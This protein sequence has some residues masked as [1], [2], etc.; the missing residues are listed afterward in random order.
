MLHNPWQINFPCKYQNFDEDTIVTAT[1]Q[2]SKSCN[3]MESHGSSCFFHRVSYKSCLNLWTID[4]HL[5]RNVPK[6]KWSWLTGQKYHVLSLA[7]SRICITVYTIYLLCISILY[8]THTIAYQ[9]WYTA[10]CYLQDHGKQQLHKMKLQYHLNIRK[11]IYSFDNMAIYLF[12][13]QLLTAFA[14]SALNCDFW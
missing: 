8:T 7:N 14:G 9:K 1:H 4:I 6:I 10:F 2:G 11:I 3:I 13:I 5:Y 12:H